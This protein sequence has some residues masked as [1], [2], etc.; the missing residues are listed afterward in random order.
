MSFI[1]VKGGRWW[2]TFSVYTVAANDSSAY[3]AGK[4]F[5][6]HHL[7]GLSPNKT[8]EGFVGGFIINVVLTYFLASWCLKSNF[9][10]C[11]PEHLNYGLFEDWQCET[12]L[13]IYME[14]EYTL[15][16]TFMG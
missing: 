16:F 2:N 8:I 12:P 11:A 4:M 3:F 14:Q 10:T 6:K 13:P 15:P 5:G 7:I 9:W 1:L